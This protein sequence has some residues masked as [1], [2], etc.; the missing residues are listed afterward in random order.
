MEMRLNLDD[1]KSFSGKSFGAHKEI[2]GEVVFNTG[3]SGY[4]ETLTDPSYKGQILVLTYPLQGNYG[5][6][7]PPYESKN[8]QVQG[9]IV[10]HYSENPS[11]HAAARSLG[12]WLKDEGIPAIYGV[13]TRT[14]TRH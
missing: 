3:M 10:T 9:L 8:I 5:V 2:Q 1:G 14:L 7:Q 13:D 12:E 6:P 11:H 4:V